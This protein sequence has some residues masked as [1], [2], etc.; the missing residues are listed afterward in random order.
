MSSEGAVWLLIIGSLALGA[1]AACIFALAARKN[2]FDNLED[3]KYQIFWSDPVEPSAPIPKDSK[4]AETARPAATRL[5]AP[6]TGTRRKT[7]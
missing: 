2:L 5:P 1:A 3:T 4:L 6:Q 7:R